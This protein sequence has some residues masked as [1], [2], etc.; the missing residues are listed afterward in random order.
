M[1]FFNFAS[2]TMQL[3]HN[4]C[5]FGQRQHLIIN[6]DDSILWS[7]RLCEVQRLSY[8][9]GRKARVVYVLYISCN[10]STNQLFLKATNEGTCL[11]PVDLGKKKKIKSKKQTDDI[12]LSNFSVSFFLP[13]FNKQKTSFFTVFTHNFLETFA[14]N[15]LYC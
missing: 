8:K 15:N 7:K 14:L 13:K 2:H 9:Y 6:D 11:C 3:K 12:K 5:L 10:A 1:P 4:V